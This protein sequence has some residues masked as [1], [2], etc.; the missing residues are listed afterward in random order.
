MANE[1][2]GNGMNYILRKYINS[3]ILF[4]WIKE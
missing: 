1:R 4:D 2:L 3:M